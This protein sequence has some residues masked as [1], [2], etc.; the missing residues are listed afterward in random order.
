MMPNCDPRDRFLDQYLALVINSFSSQLLV[1]ALELNQ[2]YFEIFRI[3][4]S[5]D[6][7]SNATL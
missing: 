6:C 4:V 1:T 5:H 7:D 2:V 3:R